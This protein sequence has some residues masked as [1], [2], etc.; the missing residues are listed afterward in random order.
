[1]KTN[2]FFLPMKV[3]TKTF[4]EKKLRTVKGRAVLYTPS[5]LV[6][7]RQKYI[8]AL[9]PYAPP[10][11]AEGPISLCL[12]FCFKDKKHE[13]GTPKITKPDTDNMGKMFKDCMTACGFWKDD[14]QIYRDYISK[15]YQE[16]E[17]VYVEIVEL[18]VL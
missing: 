10:V 7:I 9:M 18:T 4:Q 2:H 17:G 12:M 13:P 8:S 15:S 11:P 6:E 3:P 14:A 1:M 5:E 16:N